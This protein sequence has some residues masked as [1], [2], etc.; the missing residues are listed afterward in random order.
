[1]SRW[2]AGCTNPSFKGSGPRR[3]SGLTVSKDVLPGDVAEAV[4]AAMAI[5]LSIVGDVCS[6]PAY[7]VSPAAH[8]GLEHA[9]YDMM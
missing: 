6:A 2:P 4:K 3:W 7:T 5:Q 1:M 8:A 9:L